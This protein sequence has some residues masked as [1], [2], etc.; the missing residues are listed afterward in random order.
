MSAGGGVAVAVAVAVVLLLEPLRLTDPSTGLGDFDIVNAVSMADITHADAVQALSQGGPRL[1]L[2]VG[3][4]VEEA[5]CL[6]RAQAGRQTTAAVR[7]QCMH[8]PPLQHE[9]RLQIEFDKDSHGLGFSIAGGTDSPV[10]VSAVAIFRPS[11]GQLQH[12][13]RFFFPFSGWLTWRR[14]KTRASS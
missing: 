6:A 8:G 2:T 5:S 10:E 3:H 12:L 7:S 13:L 11:Q 9:E 1:Q 14:T 4:F